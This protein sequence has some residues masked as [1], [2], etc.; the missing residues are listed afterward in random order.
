MLSLSGHAAKGSYNLYTCKSEQD[1]YA[2]NSKCTTEE[3]KLDFKV[4]PTNNVVQISGFEKGKLINTSSLDKCK[5][6]DAKNW[7]CGEGYTV[8]QLGTYNYKQAMNDGLYI[9]ITEVDSRITK[10]YK[11]YECAKKSGVLDYFGF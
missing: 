7:T 6:I 2:C 5:V 10:G 8:D 3:A 9:S 1:A 11:I 4:N